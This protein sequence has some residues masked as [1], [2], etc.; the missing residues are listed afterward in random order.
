MYI[1]YNLLMIGAFFLVMPYFIYRSICEKGFTRRM[2]QSLGGIR[3]EE[4][5]AVAL[6]GCIWIHGASV[7]EIVATSPLVK[8]IRKAMPEIP[9][10]VSA[11]TVGGYDMAR[12]IIPEA[13]AII[14][15]PLDLP[16][17]SES[18]VKRIR[19]R[20]FMPVETE[21]WPDLLR[22]LRERN[23]PV[24]MV[25][26]RISE[27]S[28]KTYRYLYGIWD[29]MLNTVSRFC[30]QSSIDADYIRLLWPVLPILPKKKPCWRLLKPL[31]KLI[32][33]RVLL[34]LR[35]SRN[36]LTKLCAWLGILVMRLGSVPSF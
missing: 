16:F 9:I 23:I 11:V 21:L 31:R 10:L 26:G 30:M 15:F 1:I 34:L 32:Q 14:Y 4:I 12:Q 5:E 17:V 24:M 6:K 2:R 25:N 28:V 22:A 7:G 29:D 33:R 20:I 35:A 8:E 27:K 13:D 36:A 3:D 18:V 19:P